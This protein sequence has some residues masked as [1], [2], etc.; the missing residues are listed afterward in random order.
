MKYSDTSVE[1]MLLK[2]VCE[3]TSE[4]HRSRVLSSLSEEHFVEALPIYKRINTLTSSGKGFPTFTALRK[5]LVIPDQ[6]RA[7]LSDDT[8]YFHSP[9]D[10][11]IGINTLEQY[12]QGRLLYNSVSA[13]LSKLQTEAPNLPDIVNKLNDTLL[14]CQPV[15]NDDMFVISADT[16]KELAITIEQDLNT[17]GD[18]LIPTSFR[19]FDT[20]TGGLHR[21]NVMV[22]ASTPGGGK[23][24]L[25]LYM[26]AQQYMMGYNVC[27]ISYEMSEIELRYRLLASISR[28]EH[29]LINLKLL[30][31]EQKTIVIDSFLDWSSSFQRGN[32]FTIWTPSQELDVSDITMRL[33]HEGY[34]AIY[35][36]YLGLLKSQDG[37]PQHEVLGDHTRQAKLGAN[38]LNCVYVLLAQFDDESNKIK[39]SKAI[40][41]N[42]NFI[43][44]WTRGEM[45]KKT[46][47][48]K[49]NMPKARSSE[50]YEFYLQTDLKVF[51][52]K[53]YDGVIPTEET[54]KKKRKKDRGETEEELPTMGE[55][56][57]D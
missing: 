51:L 45:E 1:I 26:A 33:R 57:H 12:R 36:D 42:A 16:A 20:I 5:D 43:W 35:V 14:K 37:K 19:K 48:I 56:Q 13:A 52:F 17:Q 29:R 31:D 24:A 25:A 23:S 3:T 34:D 49:I 4:T 50:T 8:D 6:H 38:A 41:A 53:D 46:N 39:Y 22:L 9:D 27:Y 55:L 21:K 10:I 54:E 18:D 40:T 47:I 32:R 15:D 28:V 44:T 7:L 30:T 11:D 2:T